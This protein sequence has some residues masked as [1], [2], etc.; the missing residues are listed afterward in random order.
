MQTSEPARTLILITGYAR[1][2][3][4][5]LAD[6]LVKEAKH[7]VHRFNFADTLKIACDNYIEQLGLAGSF[8]DE[9]FKV[10]HRSFLVAAG[11]FARSIDCD[12]FAS[13]FVAECDTWAS[14]HAIIGEP[15]TV[16]CSDWR[17]MNELRIPDSTLGLCGWRI[18][19]VHVTTSNVEAANEEEG[20]SIGEIIRQAPLG[21][22]YYFA[23]N[24][25]AA[26][27]T[28]GRMLARTLG[29]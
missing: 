19:T 4:D 12:V 5:T 11:A 28:E 14:S 16:I 24:S 8:Y 6:G 29:I 15:M 27:Q 18:I 13:A 2:G 3:K 10:R 23:P 20:K 9:D 17:Y 7:P 26:I 21:Y 25:K 22:S 1:A